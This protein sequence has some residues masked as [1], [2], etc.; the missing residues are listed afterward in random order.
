MTQGIKRLDA[1]FLAN[2]ARPQARILQFGNG[3]FMRGF[4]DWHVDRLNDAGG[5]WGIVAI[6]SQGAVQED[7]INRQ[8]GLYT[9][10]SR[11]VARDGSDASDT[12]LVRALLREISAQDDWAQVLA[13]ASQPEVCVVASNTTEAG[14]VHAAEA[15]P[16]DAPPTSF[17]ARVARLLWQRWQALGR[18]VAPGMQFL[19]C[20]LIER[21]GAT[22]RDIVLAHAKTWQLDQAFATWVATACTF[23]DTLVDRIVPGFPANE[24]ADWQQRLG[25]D[26]QFLTA[27][28][29]Y[30][31]FVIE[32]R[33]GM[34]ELLL[35]LANIDT[36]GVQVVEDVAPY[37][38]RKVAVL[39]GAHTALCPLALMA[40]VE[41][42]R[43][44]IED[45]ALS[46]YLSALLAREVLPTLAQPR[47]ELDAYATDI[48][49]RFANPHIRHRWYDI[50]LNGMAK[51]R[52]RNLPRLQA[53]LAAGRQAPLTQ[54]SLA[55]WLLAY[56]GQA[57][58]VVARDSE[59]VLAAAA[60]LPHQDDITL[61]QA[62]LA[63][64]ALW[65]AEGGPQAAAPG[66][67]DTLAFLRSAPFD[68]ARLRTYLNLLG[69]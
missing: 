63:S 43:E 58:G 19:P 44:A 62:F 36:E 40:G 55:A 8:D 69:I 20:E 28:E 56:S 18:A 23:Y 30:H 66:L 5:D 52:T 2:P 26:D 50:S 16:A 39:N 24:A 38:E 46:A 27:T 51:F 53:A 12:R 32:R 37:R 61:A 7:G 48:L 9:V 11:G 13:L 64:T 54:L 60:A 35:P 14:I 67:A 31:L 59:T 22:L 57:P 34:A 17:P 47:T 10:V 6:R 29:L 25:Y 3:N 33:P 42:V 41:T 45:P 65:G 21:N 4:F 15:W 1:H 49:R 68:S